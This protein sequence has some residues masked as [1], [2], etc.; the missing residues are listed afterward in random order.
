MVEVVPE[1]F[2]NSLSRG[3]PSTT[4]PPLR[5]G[6]DRR[7]HLGDQAFFR[8]LC[9]NSALPIVQVLAAKSGTSRER[10]G[11]NDTNLAQQVLSMFLPPYRNPHLF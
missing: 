2:L 11:T 8:N 6:P 4:R 1:E 10:V 5:C 7:N 3:A 9:R